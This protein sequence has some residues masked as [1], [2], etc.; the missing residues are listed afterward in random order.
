MILSFI[1]FLEAASVLSSSC[2]WET[3]SCLLHSQTP[4]LF[5]PGFHELEVLGPTG[6]WWSEGFG[7]SSSLES[8]AEAAGRGHPPLMAVV[9]KLRVTSVVEWGLQTDWH[10]TKIM[11]GLS[12][13]PLKP[14]VFPEEAFQANHL[15]FQ[16]TPVAGAVPE[17]HANSPFLASE[18]QRVV[19]KHHPYVSWQDTCQGLCHLGSGC[20]LHRCWYIL[21]ELHC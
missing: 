7:I 10:S 21:W 12:A 19:C 4:W 16:H 14:C 11:Y 1:F 2:L 6:A 5:P 18:V 8:P 13:W 3:R 17:H 9:H 20:L 15:F